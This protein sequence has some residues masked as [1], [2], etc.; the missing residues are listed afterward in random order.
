MSPGRAVSNVE[1]YILHRFNVKELLLGDNILEKNSKPKIKCEFA[2][3]T[4][5]KNNA[6]YLPRNNATHHITYTKN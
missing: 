4:I 1:E 5:R 2:H 3:S 6:C